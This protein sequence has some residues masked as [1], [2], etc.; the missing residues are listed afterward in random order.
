M[1]FVPSR[2][3]TDDLKRIQ[4]D[5]QTVEKKGA[6]SLDDDKSSVVL[7]LQNHEGARRKNS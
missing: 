2:A 4:K 1:V 6:D 3:R 5:Y 7:T